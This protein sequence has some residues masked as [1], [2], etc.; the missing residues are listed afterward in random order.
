MVHC[1]FL[2]GVLKEQI[3]I[4]VMLKKE[5]RALKQNGEKAVNRSFKLSHRLARREIVVDCKNSLIAEL[6]APAAIYMHCKS[7][8]ISNLSTLMN[9]L[10]FFSEEFKDVYCYSTF[11]KYVGCY[12]Y[13][14]CESFA[15]Q[16]E[17]KDPLKKKL[18]VR[19]KEEHIPLLKAVLRAFQVDI[20]LYC[21]FLQPY[22]MM[23]EARPEAPESSQPEDY[24]L[25]FNELKISF[26]NNAA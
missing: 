13:G 23:I 24:L 2:I 14:N 1:M 7:L 6:V 5:K 17:I 3:D 25:E 11:H 22:C 18:I 26:A 21:V 9:T 12:F 20:D 15:G 16:T 19:T 8:T 4:T 10:S